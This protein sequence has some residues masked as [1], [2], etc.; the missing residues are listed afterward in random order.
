MKK[1]LVLACEKVA[2]VMPVKGPA[3][4]EKVANVMPVKGPADVQL[5]A[6]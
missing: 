6:H 3:V 4:C 1:D 2:N 5:C